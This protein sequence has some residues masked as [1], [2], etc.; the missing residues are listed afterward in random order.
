MGAVSFVCFQGGTAWVF[1][2][3]LPGE[4]VSFAKYM[5]LEM[6][7]RVLE[8]MRDEQP[9]MSACKGTRNVHKAVCF[10]KTSGRQAHGACV[11]HCRCAFK[12]DCSKS[13]ATWLILDIFSSG[14]RI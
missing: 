8:I 11:A 12:F 4:L 6:R 2:H 13:L 10:C 9:A 5:V 14:N 1:A 3:L 7:Y